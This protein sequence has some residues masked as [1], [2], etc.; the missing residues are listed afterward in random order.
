MTTAVLLGLMPAFEPKEPEIM[1]RPPR[2]TNIPILTRPLIERIVLVGVLLLIGAFGLF[3]WEILHGE[4]EAKARTAAVNVFVFGKLFY[5]F[6][7]RSLR[8][9]MFRLGVFSNSWVLFVAT[10]M[11]L[12]QV[13]ITYAPPK[14][15]AFG[16]QSIGW[17]EWSLLQ[18]TGWL[19]HLIVGIEKWLRRR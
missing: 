4:S 2:A 10:A 5:M 6:N 9:S 11:A 14:N 17:M 1:S 7:C 16:S 3:E 8:Y 12:L 15:F 18:G 13:L 19:I